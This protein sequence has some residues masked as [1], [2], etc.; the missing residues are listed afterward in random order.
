MAR[1]TPKQNPAVFAVQRA[2]GADADTQHLIPVHQL[3]QSFQL[4]NDSAHQIV[5]IRKLSPLKQIPGHITQAHTA[6]LSGQ[7]H[8]QCVI[9]VGAQSKGC[10]TAAPAHGLRR[11]LCHNS[12]IQ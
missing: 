4:R 5:L 2:G 8:R 9:A 3:Q 6:A 12:Q 10:G 11:K 7:I 1:E